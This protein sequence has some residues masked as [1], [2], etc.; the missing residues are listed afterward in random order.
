[1]YKQYFLL[2]CNETVSAIEVTLRRMK[3]EV[4]QESRMGEDLKG[5]GLS[6]HLPGQTGKDEENRQDSR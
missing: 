4:N 5:G 1:M 6:L 2:L 3:W